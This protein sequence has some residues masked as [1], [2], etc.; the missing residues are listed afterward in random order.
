MNI[1]KTEFILF[2]HPKQLKKC[3]SNYLKV[4]GED[5]SLSIDIR[6]LGVY[7]DSQLSFKQ[8]I[9]HKCKVAMLN[10]HRIRNIRSTLTTEATYTLV[11]GFVASHLDFCNSVLFG[12]PKNSIKKLQRVQNIAAK[13]VLNRTKHESSTES[14]KQLHWLPNAARIEFKI[15]VLVYK[16]L[17]E[18]APE[19]LQKISV[20]REGLR[21]STFTNNFHVPKTSQHICIKIFVAVEWATLQHQRMYKS[22]NV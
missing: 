10:I 4:C 21:S 22:K 16:C 7:L 13:L 1:S 12:L 3:S 19:Y 5:I 9:T 14:R 11:L 17:H 20:L 6:Y 15:I 18:N 2:G 8:H